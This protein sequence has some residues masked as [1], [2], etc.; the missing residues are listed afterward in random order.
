MSSST[1]TK[2]QSKK[3]A[4][5]KA[6]AS[7]NGQVPGI[8]LR[9]SKR[10]GRGVFATRRFDVGDVIERAPLIVLGP[11]DWDLLA[12]T[13]LGGYVYDLGDDHCGLAGGLASFYNHEVP[14]NA[15]YHADRRTTTVT[16]RAV[17]RI[18]PGDE[19][20]INYNGDP[21]SDD[22]VYFTG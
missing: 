17:R 12:E 20:C 18:E 15:A 16:I 2:K 8:E 3:K 11:R 9:K 22:R 21:D 1:G 19:V 14:A 4:R 5:S 13:R 6:K 7:S 10:H